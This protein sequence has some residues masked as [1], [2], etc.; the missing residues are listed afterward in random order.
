M[1]IHKDVFDVKGTPHGG[2]GTSFSQAV[3][4]FSFDSLSP[5]QKEEFYSL[6]GQPS[7]LAKDYPYD[8]WHDSVMDSVEK[9]GPFVNDA[10]GVS[11]PAQSKDPFTLL[12]DYITG[13]VDY[14]RNTALQKMSQDFNAREAQKA[15]DFNSAE[16]EIARNWNSQEAR[17]ARLFNSNEAELNRAFQRDMSNT[18][19]QRAAADMRAAGLN[20]YL[21]YAQGGAPVT[22][23]SAAAASAPSS[24]AASGSAAS[25]GINNAGHNSVGQLLNTALSSIV[26]SAFKVGYIWKK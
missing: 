1:F 2:G 3:S 21:V 14:E 19:Y 6:Y 15:R 11:T 8:S 12:V 17:L 16:A 7:I 10:Q 22:S 20:P 24:P 9:Y 18:A 5:E 25:S 23:G 4:D 13:G 26:S